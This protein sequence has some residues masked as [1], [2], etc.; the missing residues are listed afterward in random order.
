MGVTRTSNLLIVAC[1][2][3]AF[4]LSAQETP[5]IQTSVKIYRVADLVAARAVRETTQK[6]VSL[7][8][9]NGEH[10]E[11]IESLNDLVALIETII[12]AE[13]GAVA[14]HAD[15]LSLVIRHSPSGHDQIAGLLDQLRQA[16]RPVVELTLI[17]LVGLEGSAERFSDEQANRLNEMLIKQVLNS[18]ETQE[19][20]KLLA[21]SQQAQNPMTKPITA[22]LANGRKTVVPRFMMPFYTTVVLMKDTDEIQLRIDNVADEAGPD[23]VLTQIQSFSVPA[24]HSVMFATQIDGSVM[25]WMAIPKPI[26]SEQKV[27]AV[28]ADLKR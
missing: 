15:S 2:S 12:P 27:T 25:Y 22:R 14:A 26:E 23:K 21:A 16:E 8:E 9:W 1:L 6:T 7:A 11:S 24:G 3:M 18:D 5:S 17:P 19:M 20:T 28:S 10:S 13:A 4:P